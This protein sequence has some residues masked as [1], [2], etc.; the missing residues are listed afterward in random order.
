MI[1]HT[2]FIFALVDCN[3]H[4]VRCR[5]KVAIDRQCRSDTISSNREKV[6]GMVSQAQE[7]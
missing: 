2:L 7:S 4:I 3:I 6:M 5:K 1:L